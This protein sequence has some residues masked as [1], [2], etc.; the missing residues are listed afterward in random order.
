MDNK[1][2]FFLLSYKTHYE[3]SLEYSIIPT[4]LLY[5]FVQVNRIVRNIFHFTKIF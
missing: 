1:L 5:K 4:L 2:I 3:E